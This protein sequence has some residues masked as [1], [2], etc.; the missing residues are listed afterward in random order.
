MNQDLSFYV[1]AYLCEDGS[2]YYIGKGNKFRAWQSTKGHRPPK[3]KS[4]I[5][6]I[7]NN[8]DETTAFA[9]EKFW[10]AVYGRKDIETGILHNKTDGGDGSSNPSLETRK[11]L[12]KNG[13]LRVQSEE[14]R[15]KISKAAT[16]RWKSKENREK[17]SMTISTYWSDKPRPKSLESITKMIKT[18]TGRK[19]G[20]MSEENKKKISESRLLSRPVPK[21]Q[22]PYCSKS[23]DP[24]NYKKSHGDNCKQRS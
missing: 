17:Q 19:K 5:K 1:Y 15:Q 9:I 2:P 21:K 23:V 8:L 22:C 20:P 3:D 7:R 16:E 4:R 11:K 12:S 13:K 6:I 18:N 14:T 10:I 24:G